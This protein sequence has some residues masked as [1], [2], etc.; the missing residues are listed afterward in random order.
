MTRFI[1]VELLKL[2]TTRLPFGLL[3]ASSLLTA[4]IT[5]LKATRAGENRRV[6]IPPLYTAQGLK[7]VIT[8]TDFA[9]IMALVFGVII[10]TSEFRHMTATSTYLGQPI[11]SRVLVAKAVASAIG[12][13]VFGAVASALTIGIALA[14]VS[15]KGY[16]I[17]L[18]GGTIAHYGLG[19]VLACAILAVAGVAV[20]TLIRGQV[21]AIVTVFAWGFIIESIIG[22][23]YNSAQPYLPYTAARTLAGFTLNGGTSPMSFLATTAYVVAIALA[24][25]FISART[26]LRRDIA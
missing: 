10:A 1:R 24:L 19:A 25:L 6:A 11:R 7:D 3:G 18:G 17:A 4:L 9:M 5:V 15:G 14:F 13:A 26:T 21:G 8:S 12:G 23:L 16:S 20:G 2:W 22:G